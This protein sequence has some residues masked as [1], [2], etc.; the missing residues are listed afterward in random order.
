MDGFLFSNSTYCTV[1]VAKGG[2]ARH[3]NKM[4]FFFT[5]PFQG[6][7]KKHD[8]EIHFSASQTQCYKITVFYMYF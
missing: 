2:I 4:A 7:V 3:T 6:T 8:D 5:Q 1:S